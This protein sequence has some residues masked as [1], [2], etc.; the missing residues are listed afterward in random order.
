M[1][2]FFKKWVT[3]LLA[4]VAYVALWLAAFW[5][6]CRFESFYLMLFLF[7]IATGIALGFHT[8]NYVQGLRIIGIPATL[9]FIFWEQI[10]DFVDMPC[11]PGGFEDVIYGAAYMLLYPIV[12]FVVYSIA[13]NI[14]WYD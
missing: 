1:K 4:Y 13:Y 11:S 12:V 2:D 8:K 9:P 5:L 7:A 14:K 10:D 3:P 6:E